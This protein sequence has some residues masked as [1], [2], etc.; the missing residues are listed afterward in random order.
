MGDHLPSTVL[1]VRQFKSKKDGTANYDA[2]LESA[3]AAGKVR[4]A[5]GAYWKSTG[6]TPPPQIPRELAKV[7]ISISHT[8]PTRVRVRILK[9]IAKL[10]KAANPALSCFVTSYLPR[11]QLKIRQ[12]DG[13]MTSY[14]Y[15]EAVQRFSHHL[16]RDFLISEASYAKTNIRADNLTSHFLILSPDLVQ[17]ANPITPVAQVNTQKR[18]A[19]Q[20]ASP[21][22]KKV[23]S[24][25][26]KGK[27]KGQKGKATAPGTAP[28]I[29]TA[30]ASGPPIPVGNSFSALGSP[31]PALLTNR[32]FSS[33]AT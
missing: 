7:S 18:P 24:G 15:V 12:P 30:K 26:G 17:P 32:S 3:T 2:E 19:D 5:F 28:A 14:T 29:S 21:A 16:T 4:A 20:L 33:D 27:G 8:F 6:R 31:D 25:K 1:F 22:S 23:A 9:Q 13:R 10:H 11:P